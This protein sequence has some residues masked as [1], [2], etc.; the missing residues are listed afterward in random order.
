TVDGLATCSWWTG[1]SDVRTAGAGFAV[2]LADRLERADERT[3]RDVLVRLGHQGTASRRPQC[4]A[5]AQ[6]VRP[7]EHPRRR[8]AEGAIQE[9]PAGALVARHV[10]RREEPRQ[11]GE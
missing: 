1:S 9:R 4:R 7:A 10:R 5:V 11:P 8:A 3:F 2:D 6:S